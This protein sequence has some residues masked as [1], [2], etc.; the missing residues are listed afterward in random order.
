MNLERAIRKRFLRRLVETPQGR[1]HLLNLMV[2]GEE[3]DEVGV[4]DRLAALADDEAGRKAVLRHKADEERHAALYR[5]CLARTG[6]E[7]RP[8]P[9]RLM[10][11]RRIVRKSEDVFA[12]GIESGSAERIDSRQDLMN[13]YAMLLVIEERALQQFPVVGRLFRAAGD[14]ATADV[15]EQVAND[16]RR[17]VKYC[18]A[19]GRRYAPNA[20]TW[21]RAIARYRSIEA[22]AYR[23]IGFATIGDAFAHDLLHFGLPGRLLGRLLC[24]LDDRVSRLDRRLPGVVNLRAA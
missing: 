17:H 13:T 12:A 6:I 20:A 18:Q 14:A 2:V 15:F 16:E 24:A 19:L 3:A 4:F 9:E 11:V 7:P 21:E 23:E 22:E 1:A 8:V 5:S 10:L